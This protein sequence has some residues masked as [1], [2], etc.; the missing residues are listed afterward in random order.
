M[1]IDDIDFSC[2][3]RTTMLSQ[4]GKA[5]DVVRGETWAHLVKVGLSYQMPESGCMACQVIRSV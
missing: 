2:P 1:S 3:I 5:S 4:S